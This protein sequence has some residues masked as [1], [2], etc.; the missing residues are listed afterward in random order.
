MSQQCKNSVTLSVPPPPCTV[1]EP[2]VV[3]YES[4]IAIKGLIVIHVDVAMNALYNVPDVASS[5][6]VSAI[7]L[8]III[9]F[10]RDERGQMVSLASPLLFFPR[11]IFVWCYL[12]S[13]YTCILYTFPIYRSTACKTK[14][15][16][17]E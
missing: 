13:R 8:H 10:S 3:H 15:I 6:F 9:L 5:S 16:C 17:E 1:P 11:K 14:L 2:G 12:I 4:G 7:D